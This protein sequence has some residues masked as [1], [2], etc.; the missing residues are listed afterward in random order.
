MNLF[1]RMFSICFMLI[2]L[3]D[4][5]L[6]IF[7]NE[8]KESKCGSHGPAVRFP[9]RIKG[10]QPDHCG[11]PEDGFHLSCSERKETV[12]ELPNSVK[13]SINK[14]DYFSQVISASDP[15]GCFPKQLPKINLS[16]SSFRFHYQFD[17]W[18]NNC[19]IFH[20][21]QR[22]Q[23]SSATLISCQSSPN[24]YVYS[25]PSNSGGDVNKIYNCT[26]M[27]EII[28]FPFLL[29]DLDIRVV[30]LSWSFPRCNSCEAHYKYCRLKPNSTQPAIECYG[31]LQKKGALNKFVATGIALALLLL[32]V[33]V[34]A[35]FYVYGFNKKEKEY[36]S[37]IEK[38]LDDYKTFK[39][40]R[41]S[42]TDIKR[43]TN[44]FKEELGQGAYG[45]VYKGKLSEEIMVAVKV[46]NNSKGNGEE[47]VNEVGIIGKIHHVNVVRLI[48]FCA[49]GFRRALL[50][51]YLPNE[52]LAKFIS[53]ADAKNH[54]LGW[55]RLQDIALGVAKG[56]EY[57]H[58][59]C[60]QR[61]L[62]F[63]IN[64]HNI[65]LDHN[66]NPKI[67]DFGQ[68][69]LCS[70]DQSA[71]SLTT[72][73][74]T[75]G[76]IA[77]EVFSRNFGNVSCKSDVYSFGML[78]LEMVGGR[79]NVD[80]K[81]GNEDQIYYPE[82]IYNLLEGGEDLRF[83]IDA[84]EDAKIAKKLAIVGLWCIQWNPVDRPSMK[85]AVQMLEGEGDNLSIPANP[86]SSS[87]H[88]RMNSRVSRRQ[89]HHQLEA[90][91]ETE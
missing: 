90:I 14:I 39:P 23:W 32:A 1:F 57:L 9:F 51:E 7:E 2:V 8:C 11:Y 15:Q 53:S 26:K 74:G 85:T 68:A 37:K 6:G 91:S 81:Q 28:N 35:L 45:T 25:N 21:L 29:C 38:F 77:P 82:W 63:D 13:L 49:D 47:F 76:Y 46:L 67:S 71:V 69:K 44:Q 10:R 56:I 62:H 4:D 3:V 24:S 27:Y 61:I 34:T 87:N 75:I 12:L 64:P 18:E 19:T 73:R 5:G 80:A 40:S 70:R 58:Q 16:V 52:S 66:F 83:E 88:T 89:L 55:K 60:N 20:C 86:F 17:Y 79:K 22:T 50:Y 41:Y 33:S 54:F 72:A 42:Y 31:K 43:I 84:E 36:Q 48:G 59:G 65:L 30:R 78:V